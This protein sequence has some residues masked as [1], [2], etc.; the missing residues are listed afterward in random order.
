MCLQTYIP[1]SSYLFFSMVNAYL[2]R[3]ASFKQNGAY[4]IRSRLCF[5]FRQLSTSAPRQF[6]KQRQTNN[7]FIVSAVST[8]TGSFRSSLAYLPAPKL[9]SFAIQEAV[10]RAGIKPDEVQE[11]YMGN[12]VSAGSGQ[13][14]ARQ[15]TL[16]AGLPIS[17]PCTTVNRL[18][19][20][21]QG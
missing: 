2:T 13:A 11:V 15:A 10:S 8:L 20:V 17:T 3:T 14:P 5:H 18:N 9:G 21:L 6:G 7:V 1:S 19:C 4:A 16:G 12:V